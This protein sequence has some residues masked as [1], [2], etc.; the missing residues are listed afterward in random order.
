MKC[1]ES[2]AFTIMTLTASMLPNPDVAVAAIGLA[3][4]VYGILFITFVAFS[5]AACV[6]VTKCCIT[7]MGLFLILI[8]PKQPDSGWEPTRCRRCPGG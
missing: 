6:Q 2:W 3:Y 7:G 1:A 4:N 8:L 5:M